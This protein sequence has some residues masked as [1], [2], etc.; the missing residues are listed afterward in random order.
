MGRLSSAQLDVKP[1][2]GLN[3]LKISL[4][5]S[6]WSLTLGS[7]TFALPVCVD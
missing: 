5:K 1:L 6:L 3:L 2:E 4:E 7:K